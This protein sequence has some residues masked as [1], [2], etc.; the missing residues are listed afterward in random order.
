M[1]GKRRHKM[2]KKK[3]PPIT[4]FKREFVKLIKKL[5]Y[6]HSPYTVFGDFCTLARLSLMQP[7]YRSPELEKEYMQVV[8]KYKREEVNI[9][10]KLLGLVVLGLEKD[11]LDFLGRIYMEME[12]GNVG[13]GEFFTPPDVSSMMA[14]MTLGNMKEQI[15]KQDF[16]MVGEPAAGAGGMLLAVAKE[17][18]AQG[19]DPARSMWFDAWD[20]SYIPACMCY[21]QMAL[22]NLPGRVVLGDTL[23]QEIRDVYLTPAHFVYNWEHKLK[24]RFGKP[25]PPPPG[26]FEQ[27]TLWNPAVLRPL[28]NPISFDQLYLQAVERGDLITAQRLVDQVAE[29]ANQR[30]TK[31]MEKELKALDSRKVPFKAKSMGERVKVLGPAGKFPPYN[32]QPYSWRG[33]FWLLVEGP[34]GKRSIQ[35]ASQIHVRG[36][37]LITPHRVRRKRIHYSFPPFSSPIPWETVEYDAQ[38]KVIPLSRR[39][40]L[41]E[42]Q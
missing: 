26:K 39:F 6:G 41:K 11:P 17:A 4:D 32:R 7:F 25:E 35:P 14:K 20:V 8:G 22:M 5:S 42:Q 13:A 30:E 9:F 34:H 31:R 24:K 27:L 15:E 12:L 38:G 29:E 18:R 37:Q 23:R 28:R 36:K 10:P 19:V 2:A 16:L 40:R 33:A 3:K 21:I 1:G